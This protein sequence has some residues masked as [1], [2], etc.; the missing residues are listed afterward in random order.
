MTARLATP[1]TN[2]QPTP[3]THS[4]N[5][6]IQGARGL[7]CLMVFVY[8]VN[9]SGLGTLDFLREPVSRFLLG[10][11]EL[12]VE[13]FFGISGI[14]IIGSLRRSR[15]VRT[16]VLNRITRIL[17][18]LWATIVAVLLVAL[19]FHMPLPSGAQILA[20]MFPPLPL[21]GTG[22]VNPIAWTIDFEMAFYLLCAG[23]FFFGARTPGGIALLC[24]SLVA[25]VI[26]PRTM[27]MVAGTLVALGWVRG[28]L[29]DR[30]AHY[31][32]PLLLIYLVAW[33]GIIELVGGHAKDLVG[34]T[35]LSTD[36]AVWLYPAMIATTGV[37]MLALVGIVRGSGLLGRLLSTQAFV[38]LGNISYSFYLWHIPI[39]AGVKRVLVS[40]GLGGE[41]Y[42]QALFFVTSLPVAVGVAW[43][44]YVFIEQRF[45]A[46]LRGTTSVTIM[47]GGLKPAIRDE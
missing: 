39:M 4:K 20:S 8:H 16:F 31:T 10:T 46:W 34:P 47:P 26:Y 3:S 29:V 7:F 22:H 21:L 35:I 24:V 2:E 9:N 36:D 42:A 45:S 28:P 44:S 41:A 1:L 6:Y 33:R 23:T 19:A 27:M 13:L 43:L 11:L 14:V 38:G 18:V 37:G 12:G 15:S 5:V 40:L 30:L 17:P 25:I 32:L